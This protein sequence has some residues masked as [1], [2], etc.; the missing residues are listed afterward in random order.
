MVNLMTSRNSFLLLSPLAAFA[1]P[2]LLLLRLMIGS[3][4]VWGVWDNISSAEHMQ[5]FVSFLAK[6]GF[7]YPE[8][9]ARL[10]VW[11]QF[12]VGVSFIFGLLTRWGGII[13]AINFIVAIAIVDYHGGIRGSFASACLVV[14]GLY[15][16]TH[17]P[18]R[19][20][21]DA[22]IERSA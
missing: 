16:A 5:E 7:P 19:F 9:M 22:L 4:L 8:F 1:N 18:G 11:A 13:C 17:G 14:I 12:F 2:A 21:A 6:F 10:S 15:L 20:S 3:F